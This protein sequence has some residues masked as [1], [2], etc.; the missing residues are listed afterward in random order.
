MAGSHL[1]E[2]PFRTFWD[3]LGPFRPGEVPV[4]FPPV[5][6]LLGGP[7]KVGRERVSI[8]VVSPVLVVG[9]GIGAARAAALPWWDI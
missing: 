1:R 9:P 2:R 6:P 4:L 8:P 5:L 3:Q 7:E